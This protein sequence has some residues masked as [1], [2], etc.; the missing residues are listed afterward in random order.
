MEALH[1]QVSHH[2]YSRMC[3]RLSASATTNQILTKLEHSTL[4]I[5]VVDDDADIRYAIANIVRKCDCK[6]NEAGTIK[7]AIERLQSEDYEVVFCDVRFHGGPGG[8]EL[9]EYTGQHYPDIHVVMISCWMSGRQRADLIARGATHCLQ[10]P[11]F[12]DTCLTVLG[13]L[14]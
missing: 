9:L 1:K 10:K 2:A 5:L 8:E 4:N 7:E 11:F 3:I 14:S 13:N 12:Q 6:V